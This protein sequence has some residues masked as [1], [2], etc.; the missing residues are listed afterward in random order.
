MGICQTETSYF[1][2]RP[3]TEMQSGIEEEIDSGGTGEGTGEGR[4]G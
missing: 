4:R 3:Q 2:G 1:V